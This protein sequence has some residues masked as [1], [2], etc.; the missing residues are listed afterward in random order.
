MAFNTDRIAHG[1][2]RFLAPLHRPVRLHLAMAIKAAPLIG[3]T[4]TLGVL[5]AASRVNALD[6]NK[7]LDTSK[8]LYIRKSGTKVYKDP[9]PPR[10]KVYTYRSHNGTIVRHYT[11]P[12]PR[13][14]SATR[15]PHRSSR[16]RTHHRR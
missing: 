12:R 1:N 16:R 4:L 7:P 15:H 8:G 13:A 11:G 5:A 10:A 9:A 3:A 14:H 6:P 2:R